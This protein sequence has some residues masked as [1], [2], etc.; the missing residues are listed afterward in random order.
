MASDGN[1]QG[2][3]DLTLPATWGRK[4]K[5]APPKLVRMIESEPQAVAVAIKASGLKLAYIAALIGKSESYVSRIRS[6]QRPM[7]DKLVKPFCR[8]VGSRLLEQ[9][10]DLVAAMEQSATDD[11]RRMAAMLQEAA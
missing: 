8:A 4:P 1:N 11:I 10:R 3:L 9:Y 2:N 6:G 7:P 5:D